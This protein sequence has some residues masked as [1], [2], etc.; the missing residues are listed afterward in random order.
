MNFG[1]QGLFEVFLNPDEYLLEVAKILK[2]NLANVYTLLSRQDVT[3]TMAT[4][5]DVIKNFMTAMMAWK[6]QQ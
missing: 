3:T 2:V 5:K 6:Q 1:E 4:V